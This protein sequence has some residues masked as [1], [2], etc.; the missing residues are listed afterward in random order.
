MGQVIAA[1]AS[2]SVGELERLVLSSLQSAD[3]NHEIICRLINLSVFDNGNLFFLSFNF[4]DFLC[5]LAE[6]I[7]SR[8]MI[9][10][11]YGLQLILCSVVGMTKGATEK[12]NRK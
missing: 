12:Y 7:V 9:E 11:N 8:L 10:H 5:S 2:D 6:G 1:M 3:Q 4:F